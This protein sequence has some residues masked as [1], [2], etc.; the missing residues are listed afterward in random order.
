MAPTGMFFWQTT[1][2]RDPLKFRGTE[3]F[4][5][6]FCGKWRNFAIVTCLLG[7][8]KKVARK[9]TV[10]TTSSPPTTK[11]IATGTRFQKQFPLGPRSSPS[12]HSNQ[13]A[14]RLV[15]RFNRLLVRI[16]GTFAQFLSLFLLSFYFVYARLSSSIFK[17][18]PQKDRETK[19]ETTPRTCR[20]P[21]RKATT[22]R[23]EGNLFNL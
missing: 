3:P 23:W 9:N 20:K 1:I 4:F 22:G 16:D 8:Q 15:T 18:H 14:R 12:A 11:F 17:R 13:N 6:K 19:L 2:A 10:R 7:C 5:V 21:S